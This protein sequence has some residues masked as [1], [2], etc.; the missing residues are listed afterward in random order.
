MLWPDISFWRHVMDP[1][2]RRAILDEVETIRAERAALGTLWP[3]VPTEIYAEARKAVDS[4]RVI[5]AIETSP[6]YNASDPSKASDNLY[7]LTPNLPLKKWLQAHTSWHNTGRE[8]LLVLELVR[9]GEPVD[10]DGC[11]IE[12]WGHTP[13]AEQASASSLPGQRNYVAWDGRSA[14]R[15]WGAY[16]RSYDVHKGAERRKKPKMRRRGARASVVSAGADTAR[17]F[18]TPKVEAHGRWKREMHRAVFRRTHEEIRRAIS[19]SEGRF[20]RGLESGDLFNV[21]VRLVLISVPAGQQEDA[22]G[23]SFEVAA[24]DW[25]GSDMF[26]YELSPRPHALSPRPM[27]GILRVANDYL[28]DD[29]MRQIRKQLQDYLDDDR[30][31]STCDSVPEFPPEIDPQKDDRYF[32]TFTAACAALAEEARECAAEPDLGFLNLLEARERL[33]HWETTP[34][35]AGHAVPVELLAQLASNELYGVSEGGMSEVRDD[36]VRA[37]LRPLVLDDSDP[38]AV[39]LGVDAGGD[40]QD[41]AERLLLGYKAEARDA[42]VQD[43]PWRRIHQALVN[44]RKNGPRALRTGYPWPALMDLVRRVVGCFGEHGDI[45][46]EIRRGIRKVWI[47]EM[48]M[49]SLRYGR[50][51]FWK[52]DME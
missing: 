2:R 8:L 29:L 30:T 7:E 34:R 50:K 48:K 25:M 9:T 14:L 22:E 18:H 49:R 31:L 13:S 1:R 37:V 21:A 6:V 32:L 51:F 20:L 15:D 38:I 26:D 44:V 46:G 52:E 5:G 19:A 4:F 43:G 28:V 33:P 16:L 10:Y 39:V 23:I 36:I 45:A 17:T 35:W 40:S 42:A 41:A 47:R 3:E 11:T 24:T 27:S 12:V